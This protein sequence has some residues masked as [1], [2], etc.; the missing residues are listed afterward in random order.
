MNIRAEKEA[1]HQYLQTIVESVNIGLLCIDEEGG[2]FMMNKA[3]QKLLNKPYL[4]HL[5][6]LGQIDEGLL[7]TVKNLKTGERDMIKLVLENKTLQLAL[8]TN[9]FALRNQRLKLVSFQNIAG[10][11]EE[12]ELEAWQK[13]IRILRHEIMNSHYPHRFPHGH[14]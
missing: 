9:E 2:I 12:Q 1:N 8:Q 13:L 4:V 11:L 7:Q 14:Y 10:E 3:L 6:A 5:D